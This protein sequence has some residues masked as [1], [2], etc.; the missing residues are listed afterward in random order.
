[1]YPFH[2]IIEAVK[3]TCIEAMLLKI[4][5]RWTVQ[6]ATIEDHRL[7][8]IALFGDLSTAH[9][10]RGALRKR[11]KDTRVRTPPLT[12]TIPMEKPRLATEIHGGKPSPKPLHSARTAIET[13]WNRQRR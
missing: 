6:V 7:S 11:Y 1:M 4:Q 2:F 9:R 12:S 13:A 10:D 3:A 8:K 5:M